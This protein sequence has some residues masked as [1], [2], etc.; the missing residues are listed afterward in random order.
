MK[1]TFTSV[2]GAKKENTLTRSR[3]SIRENKKPLLD[4]QR[5]GEDDADKKD[6]DETSK[7]DDLP[8]Q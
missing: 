4:G 3:M 5:K 1:R 6:K 8:F 7:R 2:F